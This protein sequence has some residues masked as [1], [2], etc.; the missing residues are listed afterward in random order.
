[1]QDD[2]EQ[3]AG[4]AGVV[5][6]VFEQVPLPVVATAGARHRVIAANAAYRAS[7][8]RERVLGLPIEELFPELRGQQVLEMFDRV[9]T[10]GQAQ[11]GREWRL[12][13]DLDG[14]GVPVDHFY[15]FVVT[16]HRVGGTV[17]GTLLHFLDVTGAVRDRQLARGEV[18]AAEQRYGDAREAMAALQRQ[19]L[20]RGLPVLPSVLV[21]ASYLAADAEESAGGDWFDVVP[22]PDGRVGLAVGDVVGHGV[23]ASAAMAQLRAVVHDRLDE[24]G[25]PGLAVAAAHRVAR[26]STGVFGAT[27]CVV[28]LDPG[29][30]VELVSA[31]HPLP[32]VVSGDGAR[33]TTAVV[34]PPLGTGAGAWTRRTDRLEPGEVLLLY[35]DGIIERPGREPGTATAE[36]VSAAAAAV[37]DRGLRTPGLSA[38]ERA[39]TLVPELVIRATGHTDD[40]TLLAAQLIAPAP[41]W[42]TRVPAGPA[43]AG[44]VR[45]GFTDWLAAIGCG[46]EDALALQHAITELVTNAGE[47]GDPGGEVGVRAELHA[48][49]VA[50]V[51]VTDAGQWRPRA[52]RDLSAPADDGLGLAMTSHFVDDLRVARGPGGTT[53]TVR[54]QLTRPARHLLAADVGSAAPAAGLV[55]HGLVLD[56]PEPARVLLLGDFDGTSAPALTAEL[57]RRTFGG[58][59]SITL[60]LSGVSLLASA[61]VALLHRA[62]ARSTRNGAELLLFAPEGSVAQ[63]VLG[64]ASLPHTTR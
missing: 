5:L 17:T 43:A 54:H 29:G 24:T 57:E 23:A 40:V 34:G 47:H 30:D 13:L 35:T 26:R 63:H 52:A 9:L 60:D 48:D 36:L 32:L 21:S 38:A 6:G 64:L 45:G 42:R 19:L 3:R 25:D 55:R 31:G 41:V 51:A 1:M 46:A 58:T 15:D 62:V 59:V 49:G 10:T 22:L 61:A 2:D 33:D 39:T 20:P 53:V 7:A 37:A 16:P 44:A 18:A 14:S 8:G 27:L 4:A 56:S 28:A 12:Q 11:V 50:E